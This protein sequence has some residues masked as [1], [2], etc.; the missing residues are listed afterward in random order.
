MKNFYQC[1][2]L[3]FCISHNS[4]L[5]FPGS[6]SSASHHGAFP[7]FPSPIWVKQRGKALEREKVWVKN[8]LKASREFW[9]VFFLIYQKI[10]S[11][12]MR[13]L[14]SKEN[15]LIY[16]SHWDF[17]KMPLHLSG[18]YPKGIE[19]KRKV[20]ERVRINTSFFKK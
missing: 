8:C 9:K 17:R 19:T 7:Q 15:F 4:S 5:L 13:C 12:K 1:Y 20:Q 10:F 6:F 3:V 18:F 11:N 14:V 16:I 2:C